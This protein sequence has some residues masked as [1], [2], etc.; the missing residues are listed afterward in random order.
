MTNTKRVLPE[1][2]LSPIII[3]TV[4]YVIL[5]GNENSITTQ[6]KIK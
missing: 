1:N 2:H 3:Q 6:C 4:F 5:N